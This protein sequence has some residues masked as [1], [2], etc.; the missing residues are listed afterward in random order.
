VDE[1]Y[2]ELGDLPVRAEGGTAAGA[3][4]P[5]RPTAVILVASYGGVGIHTLLN[6][7]RV[8]PGH[9]A[10]VVFISVGVVNS[11]EFKGEHAV[12]ELR[13]RTDQMLAR[14]AALARSLGLPAATRSA[15]GID[16][17]AEAEGLCLELAREY[18]RA[19]FFA[20]KLIFQRERWWQRLLH[21]ETAAAVQKR[22]QWAG[23]PMMTMP[24]RV[25]DAASVAA[26][27]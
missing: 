8:F 21:N 19:T 12:T 4:D 18:P 10:N 22:L 1:L 20:G 14:Y 17:V 26:L 7:L 11:G 13:Q 23:R 3:L 9:Y 6:V 27:R 5:R 24:I 15:L 2:R 25:R 16:V